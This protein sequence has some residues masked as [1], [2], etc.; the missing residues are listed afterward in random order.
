VIRLPRTVLGFALINGCTFALDLAI[1]ST[2][3]GLLGLPLAL[4]VTVGYGIAFSLAF[5]LNRRF[6]FRS[7]E[8]VGGEVARYVAVVAVNFGVILL[9]VTMALDALGVQYQ[10]ARIVAGACEGAFMYC[11]MRWFVFRTG[12]RPRVDS[13]VDARIHEPVQHGLVALSAVPS[14]KAPRI[15]SLPEHEREIGNGRAENR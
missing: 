12:S 3:H 13:E 11:A 2:L 7:H 10:V 4:A 5:V 8:P 9:G 15:G 6:N 14:G 1:V